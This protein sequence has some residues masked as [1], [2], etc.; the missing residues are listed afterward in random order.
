MKPDAVKSLNVLFLCTGNS[1]RSIMAE[2]ILNR[3]GAGK[4]RGYSAGSHPTGRVN[5]LA[6]NLLRKSNYDVSHLNSKSW[7]EFAAPGA[8]KLDFVFTVCDDAANEVCPICPGQPMTAHWGLSDP[9]KSTRNRGRA[10]SRFRRYDAD[11]NPAHRNLREPAVREA[12]QARSSKRARQNRAYQKRNLQGTGIEPV[13]SQSLAR[14]LTA[15]GLGTGLLLAAILGSGIMGERLSGG[16][17]ALALFGNS[18]ATGAI[19]IVLIGAMGPVSGA[20]FNPLV[21]LAFLLRREIERHTALAY[22]VVQ[23]AGAVLGTWAVHLM[24]G[25]APFEVATKAR[26]ESALW[27]AEAVAT[28]S[29]SHDVRGATLARRN[30]ANDG[31]PLYRC[32]LLVHRIHELCQSGRDYCAR[33][34]RHIHRH[35]AVVS[36]RSL[37][38]KRVARLWGSCFRCGSL[39]SPSRAANKHDGRRGRSR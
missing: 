26:S 20:H 17:A 27:F 36:A 21:T 34:H 25:V 30:G 9:A 16:N 5:P 35:R 29:H 7:D 1:A 19:L 13:Q 4:F 33:A 23:I 28:F 38:R 14:R 22:I 12:E 24:F 11:A 31:W 15:E 2:C 6:L 39:A 10:W 18:T 32:G 8:P 3:L 37:P